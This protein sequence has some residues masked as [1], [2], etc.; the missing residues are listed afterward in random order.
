MKGSLALAGALAWMMAGAAQ[1]ATA[2]ATVSKID[3]SGTGAAVGTLHLRDSDQGLVIEPALDGLPP[4]NHGFHVHARGDCGPGEQ[5]G[6]KVAGLAA[7]GHFDPAN[8]GK[9]RGPEAT[10]GHKGDLPVLVVDAQGKASQ[11]VR[12]PHLTVED[13]QGHAIVI[14]GG[15]DNFADEP[16]PLGGGGPRIACAVVK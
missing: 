14:H 9:H 4:G 7:G 6:A 3:A 2:E 15:G 1:A 12:A 8:T 10:D 11:P 16:Q 5:N 13:V